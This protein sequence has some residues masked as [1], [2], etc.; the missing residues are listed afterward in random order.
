[1]ALIFA[2][3]FTNILL[4]PLFSL[5]PYYIQNIHGGGAIDLALIM[6]VFQ[7]GSLIG[8]LFIMVKNFQPQFK[9]IVGAVFIAFFGLF[10]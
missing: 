4:N 2:G 6:E 3:M 8:A 5:L 9:N 7:A 1:M 10:F